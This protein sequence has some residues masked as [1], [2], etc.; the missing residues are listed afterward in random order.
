MELAWSYGFRKIKLQLDSKAVITILTRREDPVHQYATEVL[1]FRE[2]CNR[3]WLVEVRHVYREA[4]MAAD[5]LAEQGY[6]FPFGIH[7][8]PLSDCNLGHIL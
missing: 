2:L 4:N 1:A 5:F 3:N 8:F 7:L 6:L